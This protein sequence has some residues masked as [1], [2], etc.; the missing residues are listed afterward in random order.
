MQSSRPFFHGSHLDAH[1]PKAPDHKKRRHQVLLIAFLDAT[2]AED[3]VAWLDTRVKQLGA[4]I[5]DLKVELP[6]PQR[7]QRRGFW[8]GAPK[9]YLSSP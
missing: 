1:K 3:T 5:I 8:L 9:F 7:Q 4:T 6:A 2:I